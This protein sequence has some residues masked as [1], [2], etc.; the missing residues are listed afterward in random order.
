MV[1]IGRRLLL[2]LLLQWRVLPPRIVEA[3]PL[4]AH[5]PRIDASPALLGRG[6]SISRLPR[7]QTV[8]VLL[9]SL[10]SPTLTTSDAANVR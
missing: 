10:D 5:A 2:L 4:S 3:V 7:V 1:C 6:W 9:E 8:L